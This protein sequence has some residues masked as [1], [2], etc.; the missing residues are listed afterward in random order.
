MFHR[1]HVCIAR[2]AVPTS[3][4]F[5]EDG[6][7]ARRRDRAAD[8][9]LRS[10]PGLPTSRRS[11]EA[12]E[13]VDP[14]SSVVSFINHRRRS[15]RDRQGQLGDRGRP[16]ILD[17]LR[18]AGSKRRVG[19]V[20]ERPKKRR[21]QVPDRDGP[22]A[23]PVLIGLEVFISPPASLAPVRPEPF[24]PGAGRALRSARERARV[25]RRTS[26]ARRQI[27]RKNRRRSVK[28]QRIQK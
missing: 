18:R 3:R 21:V 11:E 19:V 27:A 6:E 8:Q 23:K 7:I 15:P 20:E 16:R 24:G 13:W 12:E 1:D 28:P 14:L 17:Y 10:L 26:G 4:R 9:V 2:Q 25:D 5:A 22:T